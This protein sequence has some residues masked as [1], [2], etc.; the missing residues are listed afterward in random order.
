MD[1][2]VVD[3]ELQLGELPEL[4]DVQLVLELLEELQPE[5]DPEVEVLAAASK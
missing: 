5:L 2:E 4:L 3:V 1:A